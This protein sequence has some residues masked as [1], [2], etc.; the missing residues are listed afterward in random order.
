M[1][2]AWTEHQ[3]TRLVDVGRRGD[4]ELFQAQIGERGTEPSRINV[5]PA[6]VYFNL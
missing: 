2:E 3:R 1:K 5:Y 6:A 4:Q